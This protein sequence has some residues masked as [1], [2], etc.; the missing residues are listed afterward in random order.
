MAG[1]L[2]ARG[3]YSGERLGQ[4]LSSL[5]YADVAAGLDEAG[6][7]IQRLRW[8]LRLRSGYAPLQTKIPKRYAEVVTWKGPID[9]QYMETL[10]RAYAQK[11]MELGQEE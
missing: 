2:F 4:A 9:T 5:G 8:R 6:G 10:R 1:C 3:V 11:I 7:R